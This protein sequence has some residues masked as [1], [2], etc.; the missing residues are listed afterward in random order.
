M[1]QRYPL[2]GAPRLE[3]NANLTGLLGWS[4][5]GATLQ[6]STPLQREHLI[7][8][9]PHHVRC[10]FLINHSIEENSGHGGVVS[11]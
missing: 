9:G 11:H 10:S 1:I 6:A 5:R 7:G 4:Q 8:T 2:R 3:T